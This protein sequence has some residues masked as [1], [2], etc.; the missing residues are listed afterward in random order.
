AAFITL[1]HRYSGQPEIVVGCPIANR[2]RP[3]IENLIGSFVNTLALNIVI[4]G[5]SPFT[6]LLSEV[7]SLCLAAFAHQEFPFERLVEELQPDRNLDRNPIF[8]TFFAFQSTAS[9]SLSLPGLSAEPIEIDTGTSKFDLTLSLA[10]RHGR[11]TG[12]FEYCTDLFESATIE[13]MIGHF[14]TLLEGIVVDPNLPVRSLPLLTSSER[15]QLQVDWNGPEFDYPRDSCIHEL[16]EAQVERTPEAISV[17][18]EGKQL[19]YRELNT[20][21]NQLAHFLQKLGVGVE[22]PVGICIERSLE[23]VVGLLGILKAGGWYLPL[24]PAYPRERLAFMLED[25]RAS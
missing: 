9:P 23:M 22:K 13:R 12:F 6:E 15:R 16:F 7:R 8:Q 21:A 5:N 4:A 1:L 11:L 19:T 10:E 2:Y 17:E 14:Q 3:E 24:D 18:H 20:K 25:A